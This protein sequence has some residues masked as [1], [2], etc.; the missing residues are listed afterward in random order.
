MAANSPSK[1]KYDRPTGTSLAIGFG[2][3]CRYRRR[4]TF[5]VTL[6]VSLAALAAAAASWALP[7]PIVT[8]GSAALPAGC[9]PAT[10]AGLAVA[11][12]A[13]DKQHVVYVAVLPNREL[14]PRKAELRAGVTGADGPALVKATADCSS[15]SLLTWQPTPQSGT[16]T[17]P[18]PCPQPK[19][20][21]ASGA[22]VACA[23]LPTA[24]ETSDD[25][26]VKS[27]VQTSAVCDAIRGRGRAIA[28]LRA[29]NYSRLD[30][31]VATFD[32]N[33]RFQPY[34]ASVAHPLSGRA[35]IAAFAKQRIAAA[36]GWTATSLVG[37]IERTKKTATYVVSIVAYSSGRPVGAGNARMTLD[38]SSGLIRDWR[39]PALPLP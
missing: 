19:A 2:R 28:L 12:A 6:G 1:A 17:A 26:T 37:P 38:C 15:M 16:F 33:G 11:R 35:A 20:W 36:D 13:E 5:R 23:G 14:A 24:W 8:R 34:T 39:G 9:S 31:L 32:P 21:K 10:L 29:L 27:T 30:E 4:E 3:F 25:F 22:T 18:G 7:G